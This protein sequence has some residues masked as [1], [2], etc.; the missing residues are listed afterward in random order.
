MNLIY[1]Y[2]LFRL[3]RSWFL[4]EALLLIYV[5]AGILQPI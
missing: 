4:G 3:L 2:S 1:K 5:G